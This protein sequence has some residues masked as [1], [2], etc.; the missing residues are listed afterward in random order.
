MG[1]V[2][3]IISQDQAFREYFTILDILV[4]NYQIPN[5]LIKKMVNN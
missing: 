4:N 5:E 2:I 3:P 1:E